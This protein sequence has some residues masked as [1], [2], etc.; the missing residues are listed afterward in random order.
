MTLDT[1]LTEKKSNIVRKWIN[2]IVE[3]YPDNSQGFFKKGKNRF[4]NPV[5]H[6]L[7]KEAGILFDELIKDAMDPESVTASLDNIIR[8]RAVQDL[9]PSHAIGFML[10]LKRLVREELEEKGLSNGLSS[11]LRELENRIDEA[12]LLAFDIYSQCRQ[13]IYELRVNEV[14]RQVGRLLERANLIC[15]IPGLDSDL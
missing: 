4:A 15:E 5:G 2:L 12:A 8:I 3:T 7:S 14:K 6:T 11:E 13:K 9:K 10:R 1:L